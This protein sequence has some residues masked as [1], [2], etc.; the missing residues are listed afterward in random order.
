MSKNKLTFLR[1]C[2]SC[3]K[4][5]NTTST[6][7]TFH[8]AQCIHQR[9][10]PKDRQVKGKRSAYQHPENTSEAVRLEVHMDKVRTPGTEYQLHVDYS[11]IRAT[12]SSKLAK[13]R[14]PGLAMEMMD[15]FDA[16]SSNVSKGYTTADYGRIELRLLSYYADKPEGVVVRE[17]NKTVTAPVKEESRMPIRTKFVDY[18]ARPRPK[19]TLFCVMC[20][21]D[22]SSNSEYRLVFLNNDMH[23][24]H[25]SSIEEYTKK[26]NDGTWVAIGPDCALKLGLEWSKVKNQERA[27]EM[28]PLFAAPYG[29]SPLSLEEAEKMTGTFMKS[30]PCGGRIPFTVDADIETQWKSTKVHCE[31]CKTDTWVKPNGDC[32]TCGRLLTGFPGL[33]MEDPNTKGNKDDA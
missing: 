8:C 25:P 3:H 5:F 14:T 6:I 7:K 18:D 15:K 28:S 33:H 10:N 23:A 32:P 26:H 21:K 30:F 29:T 24:V 12:P 9:A 13:S 11:S 4:E 16:V 17:P 1:E 31:V 19:T 22:L 27:T 20:Q 2:F